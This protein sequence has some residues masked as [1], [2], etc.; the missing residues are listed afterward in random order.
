M[1][2]QQYSE[3]Q[4]DCL[5]E[6]CNVAMGQAGDTL[7]RKLG[8]F[9]TL[10]IPE[11]RI[12]EA[13]SLS[14]SL[15]NFS[16]S[17]GIYAASQLFSAENNLDGL[18]LVMLSEASLDDLKQLLPAGL[19]QEELVIDT[20]RHMAQTCLDALSEQWALGFQCKMPALVGHQS[21][22]SICQSIIKGWNHILVVEINYQLEGRFFNGDLVLLFP[23]Q[24]IAAMASRLDELLI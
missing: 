4:R 8:V 12:I 15:S 1:A 20:C 19:S 18:A 14:S 11:I 13:G 21:L 23:D 10:S 24:A 2:Q 3:D 17:A 5:Q 6:I 16:S 7:A 9:V 22:N